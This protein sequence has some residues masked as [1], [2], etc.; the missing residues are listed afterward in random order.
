MRKNWA[1]QVKRTRD[2]WDGL[3]NPSVLCSCHFEEHCF[4]AEMRL[5]ESLVVEYKK[6]LRLISG[7]V[8]TIFPRP[9]PEV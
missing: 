9:V 2:K 8:P 5:A 3:T 4:E 1:D 6:K 7:A